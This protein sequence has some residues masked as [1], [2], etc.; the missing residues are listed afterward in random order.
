MARVR[1]EVLGG[2]SA[3][4]EGGEPCVIP[5]RK[6]QALLAYLALPAGRFH[7]RDKLTALMWGD[8]FEA[9]ARQSFRQALASLRRALASAEAAPLRAE[10]GSIALNPEAVAVDVAEF[11]AAVAEASMGALEKAAS[12]YRGDLLDGFRLD[13]PGFEEWRV[14]ERERL[15]DLALHGLGLLLREERRA[16]RVEAA[17][18]TARRI[19]ALDGLQEAVHRTLMRLFLSQRRRAAALQQYQ[20]CVGVLQRELGAEPEEETRRVYY[21]ALRATADRPDAVSVRRG[22]SAPRGAAGVEAPLVG[23]KA[24]VDVLRRALDTMLEAGGR[25]AIVNGEAGIGKTRLIHEFAAHV[26][27]RGIRI[28]IASCHETEQVLPLHPWIEALRSDQPALDAAVSERLGAGAGAELVRVFPELAARSAA[29][30]TLGAQPTLL[31]DALSELIGKLVADDPLVLIVEDLHWADAMSARF[32][33]FLGRRIDRRRV[34]VVATMRPED[35]IDAPMLSQALGEL[36]REGRLD[37]LPLSPLSESESGALARSLRGGAE[38]AREWERIVGEIWAVSEGNPFV[39][40]ESMRAL[41]SQSVAS[42]LDASRVA[43][44]VQDVVGSRLDRLSELGRRVVAV[45]ATSDREFSLPML[46]RAAGV[47]EREIVTAVEELVRRR[48]FDSVGD[49]LDFCHEWIR[50]VAYDRLLPATRAILHGAV[51]D[52]LEELHHD[53]LDEVR[54]QLGRHYLRAGQPRK[55]IPHLARFAQLAAQRYAL[56]DACRALGQALQSVEQLPA[57]ERD[58]WQ[59]DLTL[60]QAFALSI[61]GRQR[62]ILELLGKH[63]GHLERV[64]DPA[65]VSEYHFR[66]GLTHFFLGDNL[67]ARLSGERALAEAERAGDPLA[68]GKSL[69]V[70]SLS[71]FDG[72]R[73]LDGIAYAARGIGL[74]DL[75]DAEPWLALLYHDLA[76]NSV[77][78][79]ALDQALDAAAREDAI[80]RL[81]HWPRVQALAAYVTAWALVLRGDV[82]DGIAAARGGLVLSRD[83]MVTG[84]LSGTLGQA[85]LERGEVAQAIESL[86]GALAQLRNNPVRSGEVRFLVPLAE[87]YLAAGDAARAQQTAWQ[88]LEVS[89]TNAASPTAALAHRALGRIARAEGRLDEAE[90]HLAKALATFTDCEARFEIARTRV[91]LALLGLE[92]GDKDGGPAHL[93]AAMAGFAAAGAPKRA[94]E[95]VALARSLHV[96]PAAP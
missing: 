52:V 43:R 72:G 51:G 25:V 33:A 56:D 77:V 40:V 46:E 68:A 39:I 8:T 65:L 12:L 90:T 5:T 96:E 27:E 23:R 42:W 85:C 66:L 58:R 64:A 15:H 32:L 3:R 83:A 9:Q 62:E 92:R 17:I 7:S 18:R 76:L 70:L 6:A 37:E 44:S 80:G 34:L 57:A 26:A 60:R 69:H 54:D 49:E 16:D 82:D 91:D 10:A 22:A 35:A 4:L 75:P 63:T 24:E 50:R 71:A 14:V 21:E 28:A 45:A 93:R 30:V 87:A 67:R 86:E 73:L 2:F 36:R 13:D 94:A 20:I 11:E 81:A 61:L 48:I 78:A 59:L 31:F 38:Q 79:G 84:L 29:P 88:A 19:L 55:A 47:G 53:R 89:Q 74:L 1:I 41:R 95:V